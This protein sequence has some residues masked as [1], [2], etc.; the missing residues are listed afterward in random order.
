MS[1]LKYFPIVWDFCCKTN[2]DKLKKNQEGALRIPYQSYNS[3]Y[4]DLIEMHGW[5][6]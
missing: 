6:K 2:N 3:N 4:D 1:D 5:Y